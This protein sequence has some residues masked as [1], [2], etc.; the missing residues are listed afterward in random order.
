MHPSSL[1]PIRFTPDGQQLIR[2]NISSNEVVVSWYNGVTSVADPYSPNA[3][4]CN[5]FFDYSK[6]LFLEIVD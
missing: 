6:V 1:T 2:F 3:Q 5:L 4:V